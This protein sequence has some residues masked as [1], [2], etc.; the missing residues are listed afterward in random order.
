MSGNYFLPTI[1]G[2][3]YFDKPLLSYWIILPFSFK[4]VVTELSS[5]IPSAISGIGVILLTFIIGRRL[6]NSRIGMVSAMLLSTSVMFVLWSRT[7]SAEMLN[8]FMIWLAFLIFLTGNY[9][10]R[11]IYIVLLYIVSA[12]AS[13]CKGPVAPAVIFTSIGS[14]STIELLINLKKKGFT[15][16]AFKEGFSS[17]FCWIFSWKGFLGLFAGLAF[18]TGL[19]LAPVILTGS[20]QSVE[21]MWRENVLRFFRPFDHIEPLYTYLKYIPLFSA[22]W[23]FF[24]LASIWEI[25]SWE[26]DRFSR[27][28]IIIAV[29]IFIF[30]TISGSRRSY[31]ILPILPALAI[32]T[33]KT[34]VDWFNMTDPLRKR[35]IHTAALLTSMLLALAGIGLLFAYFRIEIPH[36]VSQLALGAVA[37]SGAIAS[38][39]LFIRKKPFKGL[40]ILFSLIFIIE[41][42]TFTIGMAAAESKRTLRPFAQ[43]TAARLQYVKDNKIAF[44]QVGDSA[45][46]F[47]LKRNPLIYFNNPEEVKEFTYKNPDGFII[48][49]LSVLPA[50][51]REKY[52][53]KMVPI[54]IEKP[55]PDRKDD[56]LALFTLSYK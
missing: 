50:F 18:F 17:E 33:G 1:N 37:I 25:K 27:W 39:I 11:L 40:V 3:I 36:H 13:F 4:G 28:I 7:A 22:P 53:D 10:G 44:Y 2:N 15:R 49:N 42:W 8:L 35:I 47:Y 26:R 46:I 32:I 30:F 20:W 43:K 41:L 48:A 16:I 52:L 14:Y 29:T 9:G 56:P 31:Y 34:I 24:L 54:I 5:R 38:F 55:V 6:F 21:L 51:Q 19:L 12:I 23:T 45:L